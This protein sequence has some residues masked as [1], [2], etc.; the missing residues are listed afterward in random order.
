VLLLGTPRVEAWPWL[1]ASVLFNFGYYT[2]L[3]A[4]YNNGEM[5]QVYPIAR[6]T[7]PLLITLASVLLLG[8]RLSTFAFL[9]V[10]LVVAG[11]ILLS[12]RGGRNLPR[13]DRR[14]I[15]FA[16]FTA[17]MT[18]GYTLVDGVGARV[19]DNALGYAVVMFVC[20]GL[21]MALFALV[22]LGQPA[23]LSRLHLWKIGIAG[24]MLSFIAYGTAIWAMT[25][26][27]IIKVAALRETSVLFG[28]V[29][30]TL[31]LAEPLR[32]S[33]IS[34]AIIIVAGLVLLRLF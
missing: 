5:G 24:G 28:A 3:A 30:A 11:V 20:N 33:R 14:A 16:L 8:E 29:I 32:I 25:K 22:R 15:G 19:A 4:A 23:F 17:A 18:C 26:A 13:L 2:A 10:M 9:G 21:M 34:A 7:A 12:V 6:G 31:F 1:V 27:P